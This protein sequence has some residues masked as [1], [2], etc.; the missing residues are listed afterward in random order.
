MEFLK[1]WLLTI[2]AALTYGICHDQVTA[3]VCVEYFTV[4]HP[5]IIPTSSPTLLAFTW[6]I[7]ATWW[8]GVPMGLIV[9]LAARAGDRRK[10]LARD[11]L[12]PAGLLLACVGLVSLTAGLAGLWAANSG[13][14]SLPAGLASRVPPGDHARFVADWWAHSAAYVAGPAG[15]AALAVGIWLSRGRRVPRHAAPTPVP[16]PSPPIGR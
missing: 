2:V 12:M 10:V 16:S 13:V 15:A 7:V 14:E 8:V 11:L 6:G 5:T 1:I 4:G 9:A 3:R